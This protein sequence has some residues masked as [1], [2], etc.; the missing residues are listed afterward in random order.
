MNQLPWLERWPLIAMLAGA[1]LGGFGMVGAQLVAG[2]IGQ[3][4]FTGLFALA[5]IFAVWL[6][7]RGQV[8]R[9]TGP[10]DER[11]PEKEPLKMVVLGLMVTAIVMWLTAGY[12]IV[13]AAMTSPPEN[14][15]HALA[16]LGVAIAA[17]G[18]TWNMRQARNAWTDRHLRPWP[19]KDDDRSV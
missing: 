2:T 16:Y 11:T 13:I 10:V 17:T 9:L 8:T 3:V 1:V 5:L 19:R 12:G 7:V 18:A 4:I 6:W 14:K 15:W